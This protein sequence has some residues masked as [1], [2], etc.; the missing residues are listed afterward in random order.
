MEASPL[1]ASIIPV[2]VEI[3]VVLPARKRGAKQK[4]K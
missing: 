1:V 4:V 2:R 3:V